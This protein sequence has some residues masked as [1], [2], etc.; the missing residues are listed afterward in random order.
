MLIKL[1]AGAEVDLA[2]GDE[3]ENVSSKL[4]G[5]IDS[6]NDAR[7]IYTSRSA[8]VVGT[9][10]LAILDLGRPPTGSIW[11]LRY[12]T[13]FGND[14]FTVVSG[15]TCGMYVGDPVSPSLAQL[16][17]PGLA[18]PSCT[19]IPD[20]CM[21]CHPTD[22]VFVVTSIVVPAGQQVGATVGIEEW[23]LKDV[24]RLSGKGG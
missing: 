8:A 6:T 18:V 21:W 16:R 13:L 3:L 15:M 4:L 1:E 9:G 22:A 12:I 19:F 11:L 24:S 23:L 2:T 20:T 7:P 17:I 10:A 14:F 5:A